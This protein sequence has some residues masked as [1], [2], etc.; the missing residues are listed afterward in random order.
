VVGRQM[1]TSVGGGPLSR[2]LSTPW[3]PAA[4]GDHSSRPRVT[5]GLQ[6]R[7]PGLGRAAPDRARGTRSV[8]VW[9]FSG[10]GLPCEPCYQDPG[11]L[12]PHPFTL[13]G[14]F[15]SG[16]LLSVALSLGSPP[17]DVIRHPALWSS[18]F[19]PPARGR[20][21]SPVPLWRTYAS[22]GWPPPFISQLNRC[23]P[24][25]QVLNSTGATHLVR[26]HPVPPTWSGATHL[27]RCHPLGQVP[28][29]S[30]ATHLVTCR[31]SMQHVLADCSE[32]RQDDGR[33]L[34]IPRR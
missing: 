5:T 34:E 31:V 12:L 1:R 14:P 19:P 9:S 11:A 21:R 24:L 26:C 8:P 32:I 10:W 30:G 22:T 7:Y 27:V 23:H 3:S 15:R 28:T 6:R 2:V 33:Q 13:T 29:W 20:R 16:G 25:G 17:P 4:R 18:D